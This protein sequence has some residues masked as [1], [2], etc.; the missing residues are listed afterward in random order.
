MHDV[1]GNARHLSQRDGAMHGFGFGQRGAR[2]RVI[3]GRGFAFGQRLAHDDVD[4]AAVLGV[5]ADE[6]AVLRGLLQ[7]AKNSGV[8]HH[9]DVRIRHEELEAGHAFAHHV[10]HVFEA[11][12]GK[13]GDDH[14][15]PVIDAGLRF[16]LLPPGVQRVAHLGA[17]GLDGEIDDG[18]GAADGRRARAGFEIVAGCCAAERHVEMRVRVDAAGKQQHAGGVQHFVAGLGR[19]SRTHFL[20]GLAFDQYVRG[21]RLFRGHHRAVLNEDSH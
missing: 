20:D 16:R 21:E 17:A 10:V 1:D 2:E 12:F 7:R 4:H 8:I 15:Q 9:Q 13:I 6:R 3:D 19:N 18:G 11:R 5:H 14:V